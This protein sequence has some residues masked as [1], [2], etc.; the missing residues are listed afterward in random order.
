MAIEKDKPIV[1]TEIVSA[2][3]GKVNTSDALT[4]SGIRDSMDLTGKVAS[5][6]AVRDTL[7]V[8]SYHNE[9]DRI[10]IKIPPNFIIILAGD[11][12]DSCYLGMVAGYVLETIVS[13]GFTSTNIIVNAERGEVV[14]PVSGWYRYMI[15]K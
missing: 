10:T 1:A 6:E 12:S 8:S 4:L 9:G 5:A 13:V 11:G 14:L 2:L 7:T 3:N 15:I